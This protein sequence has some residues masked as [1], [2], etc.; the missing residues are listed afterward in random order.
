MNIEETVDYQVRATLFSMMRMY[1]H[2]AQENSITQGMGYVL[3]IVPREGIPATKIAPV[4]GMG[5]S[6]LGRL[7]KTME[8]NELLI[9]K[10]DDQDK[11]ITKIFL[12]PKAVELRKNIKKTVIGFNQKIIQLV[13]PEELQIYNEVSEKI[14]KVAESEIEKNQK[15]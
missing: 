11:R 10:A 9:K 8:A 13:S 5:S 3:M 12:T 1:N 15:K 6:S 14:R 4:M 2:L 7:L